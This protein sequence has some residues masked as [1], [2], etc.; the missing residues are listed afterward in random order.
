MLAAL[1]LGIFSYWMNKYWCASAAALRGA[2]V[3]GALPRLKRPARSRDA[4]VMGLGLVILANSR[5]YEGLL[6]AVIVA[7][8]MLLWLL[9][10]NRPR[11]SIALTS[12]MLPLALMLVLGALATAYYNYRVTGSPFEMPMK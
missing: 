3:L 12:V 8:A 10:A 4:V 6:L 11:R 1:R 7:V 5:S 9:G 2:L